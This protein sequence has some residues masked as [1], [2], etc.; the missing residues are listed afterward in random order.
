MPAQSRHQD[1][2][3]VAA[4]TFPHHRLDGD[5]SHRLHHLTLGNCTP[6]PPLH[7][8]EALTELALL[9]MPESTPMAAYQS[10]FTARSPLWVLHL[11]ACRCTEERRLVIDAPES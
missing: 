9:D 11:V 2:E 3:P 5:L 7:A 10:V 1:D 8:Y 6:L 4:Y